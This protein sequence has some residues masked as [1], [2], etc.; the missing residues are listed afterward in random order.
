VS[1]DSIPVAVSQAA[2]ALHNITGPGTTRVSYFNPAPVPGAI[3]STVVAFTGVS[4]FSPPAVGPTPV[5][6]P[7]IAVGSVS[8]FNPATS[9][10]TPVIVPT[11]AASAVSY[12]NGTGP[13][14]VVGASRPAGTADAA[15]FAAGP[16][17]IIVSPKEV[18]R[19][20]NVSYELVLAGAN[21]TGA[22]AVRFS[23][24]TGI[25]SGVMTVS[26]DGT[27]VSVPILVDPTTPLGTVTVSV[28]MPDGATAIT[29]ET[30]LKVVP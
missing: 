12:R 1:G 10:T 2:V 14:V 16:T 4:F 23:D 21:L 22:T 24:P 3:P 13:D 25:S 18:S 29:A 6:R 30:V 11:S 7:G 20:A 28:V 15:T 19:S 9:T 27:T 26:P 17:L 8:F 5:T